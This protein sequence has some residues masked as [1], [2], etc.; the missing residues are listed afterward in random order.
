MNALVIADRPPGT[1]ILE[2]ITLNKIDVIITLGD[3]DYFMLAELEKIHDIPKIGIYGNHDS[4]LYMEKLGISNLHLK[5]V[6][7]GGLLFGGFEGSHR[8]KESQTAKMY[9]QEE[10]VQLLR[11]FPKVDV[12]IAHSP[13]F[14]IND[15]Q[16]DA[17]H[18]GLQGLLE[19]LD[20]SHPRY[21]LHGHV[22]QN[23]ITVDH[24]EGTEMIY[25][26]KDRIV[27]LVQ[28]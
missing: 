14:G 4:G 20:R 27:S 15:D 2:T 1:P 9:T 22:Y 19:Y 24:W 21:F 6:S 16:T 23:D 5:T 28:S 3:L 18:I 7:I 26:Y 8:Y 10:S 13:P 25:V 17:A 11:D 12:F